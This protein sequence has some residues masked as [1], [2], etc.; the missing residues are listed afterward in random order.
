MGRVLALRY[1]A[2]K[3]KIAG[4]AKDGWAVVFDV[5]IEPTRRGLSQVSWGTAVRGWPPRFR[6]IQVS[7]KIFPTFRRRRGGATAR[8][9][10]IQVYPKDMGAFAGHTRPLNRPTLLNDALGSKGER[11]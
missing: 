8:F 9:R 3:S 2:F 4:V 10:T 11:S 1:D 7:P 5:L 6:T